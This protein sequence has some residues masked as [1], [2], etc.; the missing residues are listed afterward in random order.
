MEDAELVDSLAAARSQVK[1]TMRQLRNTLAFLADLEER[2]S[3]RIAEE[4][5][6][7]SEYE[8]EIAGAAV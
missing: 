2:I 7:D 6:R 4:A 3:Q 1:S 8:D 5:Q